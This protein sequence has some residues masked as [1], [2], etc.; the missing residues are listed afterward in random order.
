MKATRLRSAANTQL[1]VKVVIK[2]DVQ[3]RQREAEMGFQ[4]V[5]SLDTDMISGTAYLDENI[6]KINCRKGTLKS[7]GSSS[8]AREESVGNAAYITNDVEAKKGRPKKDY[9]EY[10]RIAVF[11]RILPPMSE[12]HLYG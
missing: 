11:Q 9:I 7:A 12:G 2:I 4:V 5:G 1:N 6:L 3:L 10:P 8:V